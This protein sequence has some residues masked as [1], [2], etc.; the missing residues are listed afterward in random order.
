MPDKIAVHQLL[1]TLLDVIDCHFFT[2][3]KPSLSHRTGRT[4]LVSL[5]T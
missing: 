1:H 4:P 2:V 3:N 5:C